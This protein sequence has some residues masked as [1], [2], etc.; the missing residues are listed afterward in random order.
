MIKILNAPDVYASALVMMDYKMSV[1]KGDIKRLID[2][3]IQSE[4]TNYPDLAR[5]I[6]LIKQGELIHTKFQKDLDNK[7]FKILNKDN[8][9]YQMATKVKVFS[10]KNF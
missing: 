5:K 8:T 6:L 7:D 1:G 3:L 4:Q 10:D 2:H 9:S